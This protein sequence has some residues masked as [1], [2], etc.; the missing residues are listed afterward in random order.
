MSKPDGESSDRIGTSISLAA[1]YLRQ[2]RLIAFPT[3]TYYGIGVDPE[4]IESVTQVFKIKQRDPGKPL[5]VLIENMEQLEKLVAHIPH[6]YHRLIDEYWP[7][8][9]TLIFQARPSVA[10]VL[11]S[12]TGTIGIRLSPNP[13][14]KE[15]IKA[16]GKPITATSANISGQAAAQSAHDVYEMFGEHIDYILDGGTTAG[17]GS[18]TVITEDSGK[19]VILRTGQLNID[20]RLL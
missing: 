17:G 18:S 3:E 8:A 6:S 10:P 2:G 13:L 5:L 11:T 14:A 19:L 12:H 4:N 9:L 20:P 15:L 1:E 7:G 16:F